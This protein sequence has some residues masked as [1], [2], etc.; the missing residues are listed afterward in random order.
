MLSFKQGQQIAEIEYKDSKK[1]PKILKVA[2]EVTDDPEIVCNNLDE[3]LPKSFYTGLKNVSTTNMILLKKAIRTQNK[4]L[5]LQGNN[6][7]HDA[8]NISNELL[9]ELLKKNFYIPPSEGKINVIPMKESCRIGVF[10]ASG[11]G[12]SYWI[13]QFLK[14]YKRRYKKNQIYVF[15]PILDDS[16]FSESKP[17]YI[18]ID[19]TILNDLLSIEE[20]SNSCCIF[21][22]IESVKDKK[23]RE[24]VLHFRDAVLETGRHEN[25]TCMCVSHIILNGSETKRLLNEAEEVVLFPRSNFNAIKNLCSRYYGMSRDDLN[26]IKQIGEKSRS[27]TIKRAFPTCIISEQ[28]VRVI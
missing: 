23:V 3:I 1:K 8:Y 9:S 15:S 2:D 7:L 27:I 13:G 5:L 25:I 18:R 17:I 21:D 16:A 22:D 24:A 26:Y 10:G 28:N 14:Q 11:V 6:T 4:N 12:K 19:E 20:F